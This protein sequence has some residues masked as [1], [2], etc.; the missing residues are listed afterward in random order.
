VGIEIVEDD[1]DLAIGMLDDDIIH[2]IK[3]LP[4]SSPG[5]MSNL[6]LAGR[7]FQG[8]EQGAGAPPLV[9]MTES[10]EGLAIGQAQPALGF[11]QDLN[12]RLLVHAQDHGLVW[13]TQ[14]QT[15]YVSG[16]WPELG[17]RR[18]APTAPPL[19]LDFVLA[20][21]SPHL[22]VTNVAELLS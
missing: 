18:N 6:Y 4:P 16:L 22:I 12:V 2:E 17:V 11:L 13:R 3:K 20:Q 10:I 5:I 19:E 15:H 21:H 1:V 8:S 9:A 14:I 7:H